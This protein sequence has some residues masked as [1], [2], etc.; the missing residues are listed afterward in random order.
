M[1]LLVRKRQMNGFSGVI[2][3]IASQVIRACPVSLV[4]KQLKSFAFIILSTDMLFVLSGVEDASKPVLAHAQIIVAPSHY[5]MAIIR[6]IRRPW[7]VSNEQ[8]VEVRK[9]SG[10]DG[11]WEVYVSDAAG[12]YYVRARHLKFEAVTCASVNS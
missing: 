4:L 12:P 1:D 7:A 11:G 5:S 9:L 6:T 10:N 2:P 8:Y 3:T